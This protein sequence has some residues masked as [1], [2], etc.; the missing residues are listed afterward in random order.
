MNK[1]LGCNVSI[2]EDAALCE[3]CSTV[4]DPT[5][6]INQFQ[7]SRIKVQDTQPP[8]LVSNAVSMQVVEEYQRT[9]LVCGKV[10][11]S[12]V[13][14]EASLINNSILDGCLGVAN[15]CNPIVLLLSSSNVNTYDSE[16]ARLKSCPECRSTNYAEIIRGG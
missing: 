3:H 6:P 4:L 5:L 8:N 12:L 2:E 11:H 1:C 14:R 15:C 13:N 7:R 16:L 10:W 9:C